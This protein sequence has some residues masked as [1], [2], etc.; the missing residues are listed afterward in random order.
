V[1]EAPFALY[2][3]VRYAECDAQKVV[4]NSRYAEYVDVAV[5]EFVRALGFGD[6]AATGVLEYQLVRQTIEWK[7]PVRFD[8]VL[9]LSVTASALGRTS[10]TLTTVFRIAGEA[11]VSATAE[12]VYVMVDGAT[13]TKI[14]LP[15]ALRAALERGAPGVVVDCSG[16]G[17]G[18]VSDP[19]S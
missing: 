12:T 7:A 5:T 19:C 15:P 10:F 13:L 1:T 2:L 4:F 3:R 9:Q 8:Q 11:A 16:T 18:H 6:A 17:V 14:P